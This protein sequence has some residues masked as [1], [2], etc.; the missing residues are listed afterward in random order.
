[1]LP[2]YLLGRKIDWASEVSSWMTI[3]YLKLN[4]A[5][6]EFM[7]LG[8][9]KRL[10]TMLL[11]LNYRHKWSVDLTFFNNDVSRGMHWPL[12]HTDIT[13]LIV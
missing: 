12:F 11:L 2:E 5:K 13:A 10:E 3:M 6:T 4:P 9:S 1:M 7:I 8:I